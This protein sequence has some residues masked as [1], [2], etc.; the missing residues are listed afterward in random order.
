MWKRAE[1]FVVRRET[2]EYK[3]RE[4][5][6]C[7]RLT[8]HAESQECWYCSAG[9]EGAKVSRRYRKVRYR[10]RERWFDRTD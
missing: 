8:Q 3:L 1:R 5:P 9:L 4:C 6:A 7:G 10:D 2:W